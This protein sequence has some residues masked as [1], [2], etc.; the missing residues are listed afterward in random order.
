MKCR[1]TFLTCLFALL[2]SAAAFAQSPAP[3]SGVN[4]LQKQLQEM[5]A[6]MA[7]LQSRIDEMEKAKTSTETSFSGP[8]AQNQNSASA[9]LVAQPVALPPKPAA[10]KSPTTF[11]SGD[12]TF[13]IGGFVKLDM[14]HD[15]N[16]IGSTDTFNVRTIPVDGSQGTNTRI[17]ANETRLS[18][19]MVGPVQGRNLKLFI[20]G[21]FFGANNV[22]RLRHAYGQWGHWLFGQTWSTFMDEDNIPDTIDLETPL[23]APFV[24][25]AL[26]RFTTNLS[27]HTQFA[28]GVEDPDPEIMP[29]PN[30]AGHPEKSLPDFTSRF[31]WN[32]N[33]GHI[34]LSGFVS[35]TR[36]RPNR[37]EPTNVAI[38][39]GLASARFRLFTRDVV[40][41]Q[42]SYGPGLGRYRGDISAA[43]DSSGRLQA[44]K[45]AAATIGYETYWWPRWSSNF[46]ASPAWIINNDLGPTSNHR[47]AYLAANVRYW[48]LE[49]QAWV[50]VEY[51]YGRRELH[52]SASGS[53]NRL[54]LAVRFNIP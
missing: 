32:N 45:V 3:E 41:A 47:F 40:Y 51:L 5:R 39:G 4:D 54:Q 7:K 22:I 50:G 43:P 8:I 31:R 53:A 2:I 33:R 27:K 19:S 14:I 18:F 21:D 28:F 6:Q 11:T 48:F 20:E 16:T 44:V 12:W 37:G 30:V 10:P 49:N 1:N 36:F 24:R 15:F 35:Q 38:Y 29:P 23:A 9:S 46:V 42:G 34:Q 25:T 26:A 52:N 17:H 13:K